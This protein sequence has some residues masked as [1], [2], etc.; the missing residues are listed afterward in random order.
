MHETFLVGIPL[1]VWK[2]GSFENLLIYSGVD[3][4]NPNVFLWFNQSFFNLEKPEE[5]KE[6]GLLDVIVMPA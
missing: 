3:R 1:K 2:A 6:G 5:L 4:E